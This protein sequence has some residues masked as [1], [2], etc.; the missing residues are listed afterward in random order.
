MPQGSV[1]EPIFILF[2]LPKAVN[3][4]SKPVLFADDTSLIVS[5]LNLVNFKND[6]IFSFEQLNAWFNTN[7]LSLNYNK[8]QYVQF[9]VTIS[10]PTQVVISYK[11]KCIVSDTNTRFL[12]ITMDSSL[13]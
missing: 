6:H 9:R 3:N 12:G 10:L 13:S 1:L 8:T 7:L 11:N 5:N 4:N 2:Y